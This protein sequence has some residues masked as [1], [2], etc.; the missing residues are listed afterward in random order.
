MGEF[1]GQGSSSAGSPILFEFKEVITVASFI[2]CIR[3]SSGVS[4]CLSCS[5]SGWS[6]GCGWWKGGSGW[7]FGGCTRSTGIPSADLYSIKIHGSDI[8]SACRT[9]KTPRTRK[10][11]CFKSLILTM[12][13]ESRCFMHEK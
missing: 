7:C 12:E 2:P 4:G 13:L 11:R 10:L 6:G 1:E 9:E 3:Y 8:W 5:C